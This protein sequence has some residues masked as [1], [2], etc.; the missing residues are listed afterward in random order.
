MITRI[1]TDIAAFVARAQE[2]AADVETHPPPTRETFGDKLKRAVER[3]V[4]RRMT[5]EQH[6]EYVEREQGR[7]TF[8]QRPNTKSG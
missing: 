2:I 3:R 7:Y 5:Q 4:F 8:K 6:R 1:P